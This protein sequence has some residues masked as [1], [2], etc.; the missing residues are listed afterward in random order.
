MVLAC[1][2]RIALGICVLLPACTASTAIQPSPDSGATSELLSFEIEGVLEIAPSQTMA[3]TIRG[4]N[5]IHAVRLSLEGTYGDASIDP[6]R[7]TLENGRAT[8]TLHAPSM[9]STFGVRASSESPRASARLDVAV[10]RE[11]FATIRVAP[12]YKGVRPVPNFVASAFVLAT[13]KDLGK[14]LSD[15]APVRSGDGKTPIDLP[16]VPAGG[17]VAVLVRVGHYAGGCVDIADLAPN[18]EKSVAVTVYDRPIDVSALDLEARFTFTPDNMELAAWNARMDAAGQ[19]ALSKLSPYGTAQDEATRLLDAMSASAQIQGFA[20]ARQSGGWDSKTTN[21]LGQH[22][23]SI[24]SRV[25]TWLA[26]G[27][28]STLAD[29]FAHF[30]PSMSQQALL[31]PTADA[32]DAGIGANSP[33]SIVVDAADTLRVEGPIDIYPTALV[34]RGANQQAVI[35]VNNATDVA[36][37]LSLQLD[38]AGLGSTLSG[39]GMC[40]ASCMKKLCDAGLASMWKTARDVSQKIGDVMEIAINGSGL[41]TVGDNAEPI[42]LLGTWSGQVKGGQYSA[43]PMHGELRAGKGMAP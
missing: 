39:Y 27:K 40:D 2:R 12:A 18:A 43:S 33:F 14:S 11:G 42:K 34:T 1:A 26:Q 22:S 8:F 25:Q 15:G 35:S 36:T 31:T 3:V 4:A 23:P 17:S 29:V 19:L 10:G 21:W 7:V 38:C 30:G 5:D 9:P 28:S 32:K 13:C 24:K 20:S 41:A 16:S 37:A 6:D